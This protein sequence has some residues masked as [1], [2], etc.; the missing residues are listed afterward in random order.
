MIHSQRSFH[1]FIHSFI[2]CKSKRSWETEQ[3]E[4]FLT[5]CKTIIFNGNRNLITKRGTRS[6][7]KN[8]IMFLLN[9]TQLVKRKKKS[10]IISHATSKS[11][12]FRM[13]YITTEMY[14]F[15]LMCQVLSLKISLWMACES[16]NGFSS[17]NSFCFSFTFH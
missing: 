1:S 4:R 10:N 11:K 3:E 8:D 14:L 15:D 5:A 2:R 12:Q 13:L 9:H 17:I 16:L 6:N 7:H